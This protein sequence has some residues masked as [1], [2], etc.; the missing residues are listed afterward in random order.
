LQIQ[1]FIIYH[2]VDWGSK[3]LTIAAKISPD[4]MTLPVFR[5]LISN[6]LISIEK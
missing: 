4:F 5:A 6:K 3:P 2:P 1:K